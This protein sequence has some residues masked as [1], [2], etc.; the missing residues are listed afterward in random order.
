MKT[1]LSKIKFMSLDDYNTSI[2]RDDV[3]CAVDVSELFGNSLFPDWSRKVDLVSGT[4]YIVGS[5]ALA[6]YKVGYIW[7]GSANWSHSFVYINETKFD[8]GGWYTGD[9]HDRKLV[10]FPVSQGD[11]VRCDEG[12]SR[13]FFPVA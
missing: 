2:D 4:T 13:Y 6:G 9:G 7:F 10:F 5:G 11:S 8:V 1:S 12:T 3:I